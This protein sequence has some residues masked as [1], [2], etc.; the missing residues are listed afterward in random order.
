MT[1][2]PDINEHRLL[3]TMKADDNDNT[4][5]TEQSRGVVVSA[6]DY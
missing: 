6:S 3:K 5:S 1:K 2:Q 4:I